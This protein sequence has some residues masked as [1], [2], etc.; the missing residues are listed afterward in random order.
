MTVTPSAMGS[1]TLWSEKSTPVMSAAA[2]AENA[3]HS[4][5][6][7]FF[8][9]MRLIS[10]LMVAIQNRAKMIDLRSPWVRRTNP[11]KSICA[12]RLSGVA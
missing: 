12:V 6:L 5:E 9:S 11:R 2:N 10:V 3:I 7:H 8:C 1:V 4:L